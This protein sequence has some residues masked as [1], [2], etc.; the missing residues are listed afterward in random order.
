[1]ISTCRLGRS[2]NCNNKIKFTFYSM[3]LLL[4]HVNILTDKLYGK[5]D[6]D[7]TVSNNNDLYKNHL[8]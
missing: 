6:L 5:V 1:M 8:L 7:T 4:L 2:N 3:K